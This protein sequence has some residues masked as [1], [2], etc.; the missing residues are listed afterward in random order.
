MKEKRI[1]LR[2]QTDNELDMIAWELLEKAT[3]EKKASK[4]SIMIELIIS[5]LENEN[6]DDALAE[7]IAELVVAKLGGVSIQREAT[8]GDNSAI[9]KGTDAKTELEPQADEPEVL[10]EDAIGFLDM[11]G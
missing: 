2:F 10:G 7:E 11:F 4:N 6:S 3:N 5:A 1:S 8:G 9:E